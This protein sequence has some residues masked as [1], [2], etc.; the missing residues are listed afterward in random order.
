L[1]ASEVVFRVIAETDPVMQWAFA[2][3]FR[4]DLKVF[5]D[6]HNIEIP[7]PRLVTYQ[8]KSEVDTDE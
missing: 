5:L 4:K 3:K 8:R 2:R 1:A 7:Y 6:E